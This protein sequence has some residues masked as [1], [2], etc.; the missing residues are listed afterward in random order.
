MTQEQL[1][2]RE[3]CAVPLYLVLQLKLVSLPRGAPRAPV[4]AVQ[5]GRRIRTVLTF[6]VDLASQDRRSAGCLVRWHDRPVVVEV[7]R[8]LSDDA[9]VRWARDV[10]SKPAGLPAERVV[11]RTSLRNG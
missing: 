3:S 11:R 7:M 5:D 10:R 1:I 2:V 6:G 8:P 4:R 9:I